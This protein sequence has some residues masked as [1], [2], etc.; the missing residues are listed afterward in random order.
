M[1]PTSDEIRIQGLCTT[2]EALI[3]Q[4][5]TDLEILVD[6]HNPKLMNTH[7]PDDS[8]KVKIEEGES[9]PNLL[10]QFAST[11]EPVCKCFLI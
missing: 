3:T 9:T 4:I 6:E 11:L 1:E 10:K 8:K 5:R 7:E 2:L